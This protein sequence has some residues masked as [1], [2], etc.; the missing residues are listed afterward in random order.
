MI[1]L[2]FPARLL[3]V[4]DVL[5]A[6]GPG[7]VLLICAQ[8]S[9]AALRRLQIPGWFMLLLVCFVLLHRLCNIRTL[10]IAQA[11]FPL[12]NTAAISPFVLHSTA[13][14]LLSLRGYHF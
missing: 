14:T 3:C 9:H 10:A 5:A 7:A 6:D 11:T 8:W 1:A 13:L 4:G 12:K 2:R